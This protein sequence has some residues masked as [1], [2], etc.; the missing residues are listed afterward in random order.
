[1][2]KMKINKNTLDRVALPKKKPNGTANQDLYWDN[3]LPRFGVRVGSGGTKTFLIEKRVN[4]RTQRMNIGRFGE[5]TAE[6]A[7][8]EA[9]KLLG[10]VA[11]GKDPIAERRA[12][13]AR[14]I[15]LQQTWEA[16]QK[17]RKD[18]KPGTLANYNKC[19][20]GCFGDWKNK[21]LVD[22]TKDMIEE[23]HREIG[24]RA[25]QRANNAMRVLRA[26]F[27][28]AMHSFE[29]SEGNPYISANPVSRLSQNRGWY[30]NK[31]RQTVL[32]SHELKAWYAGTAALSNTTARDLFRLLLFTGLRKMEGVNLQWQDIDLKSRT[33]TIQDT[34]NREPHTL[35]LTDFLYDLLAERF[36]N[37]DSPWAFPSPHGDGPLSEPQTAKKKVIAESGISFTLHD[38]RRTFI[39]VAESL[40]VSAYSLKRLVNHRMTNDVTA[41]YIITDVERLRD[42]MNK[43]SN[44]LLEQIHNG[45]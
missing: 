45:N 32:K 6:Q 33:L 2:A 27:N 7:R 23:R 4:G 20:D 10:E 31:R 41:G 1:M 13:S 22:I 28:H 16:Y 11:Q 29:D 17:S 26:L 15:T 24:S 25:P 14:S 37:S 18:L 39:T 35:P 30:P 3:A 34:K 19:I 42:P 36:K 38:L 44:Y 5:I 12:K 8:I 40:D 21:R 9:V 43:I